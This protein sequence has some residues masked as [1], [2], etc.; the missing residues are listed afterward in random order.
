M[1]FQ[2]SVAGTSI[3]CTYPSTSTPMYVYIIDF[4]LPTILSVKPPSIVLSLFTIFLFV[5]LLCARL[6]ADEVHRALFRHVAL[7]ESENVSTGYFLERTQLQCTPRNTCYNDS[8][9]HFARSSSFLRDIAPPESIRTTV[10]KISMVLEQFCTKRRELQ[11]RSVYR[12]CHRAA[13]V[14]QDV[15]AA[16]R[17]VNGMRLAIVLGCIVF[18]QRLIS[19]ENGY[20]LGRITDTTLRVYCEQQSCSHC[21]EYRVLHGRDTAYN[22]Y[23]VARITERA[24][25]QDGCCVCTS[26]PIIPALFRQ[27]RTEACIPGDFLWDPRYPFVFYVCL[28]HTWLPH[29]LSLFH[30]CLDR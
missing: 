17:N 19:R 4:L 6:I 8:V 2:A 14:L 9:Q 1:V 28:F 21:V 10:S 27:T 20:A 30:L 7:L 24:K 16:N 13:R 29:E 12:E 26:W 3:P 25:F 18:V 22:Q 5:I 11:E 23:A 15:R